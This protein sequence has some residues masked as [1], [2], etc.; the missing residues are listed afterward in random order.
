MLEGNIKII[1]SAPEV[2]GELLSGGAE[3]ASG[4]SDAAVGFVLEAIG[5]LLSGF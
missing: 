3:I 1:E 4:A 5:A 2:A